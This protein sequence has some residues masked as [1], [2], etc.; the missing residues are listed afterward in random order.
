MASDM[1]GKIKAA[2]LAKRLTQKQLAVRVGFSVS[3]ISGIESGYTAPSVDSLIA[4]ALALSLDMNE[5]CGIRKQAHTTL[6]A[7]GLTDHQL[8]LV[9]QL[10]EAL[11][12]GNKQLS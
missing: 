6:V 5:L 11:R 8:T 10:I 2:R 4:I 7:D 9:S 3:L 1:G 12:V